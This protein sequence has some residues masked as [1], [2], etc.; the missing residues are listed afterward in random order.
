MYY[1]SPATS[2]FIIR[3]Y[4]GSIPSDAFALS[5]GEYC[6]LVSNAPKGT[7]L[8]LNSEGRPE[9]FFGGTVQ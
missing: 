3:M 7:V 2:G 1:F 5:E 9:R 4:T 8:S 6:G